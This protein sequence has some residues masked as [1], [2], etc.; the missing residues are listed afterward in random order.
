MNSCLPSAPTEE[1]VI[2]IIAIFHTCEIKGD[3]EK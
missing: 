3:L 2:Y 1:A